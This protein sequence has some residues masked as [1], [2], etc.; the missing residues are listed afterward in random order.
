MTH[1]YVIRT[2]RVNRVGIEIFWLKFLFGDSLVR[3]SGTLHTKH[4]EPGLLTC[5][6]SPVFGNQEIFRNFLDF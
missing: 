2:E 3:L 1:L 5:S 4:F 6:V